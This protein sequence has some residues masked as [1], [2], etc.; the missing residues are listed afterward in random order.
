M[1]LTHKQYGLERFGLSNHQRD[2]ASGRKLRRSYPARSL[3]HGTGWFVAMVAD[4]LCVDARKVAMKHAKGCRWLRVSYVSMVS[5]VI[6]SFQCVHVSESQMSFV[7]R[8]WIAGLV[9]CLVVIHAIIIGY[10]R[11]E[12]SRVR[13]AATNEIPIG[14]YYV[15]SRDHRWLTQLRVHLLVVPERRLEAKST[16]EQNRWLIH[17]VIEEKLRQLD[18][19]LLQDAVLLKVKEEIKTALDER[20]HEE[21]IE[22]VLVN[23]RIVIPSGRFEYP[24]PYNAAEPEPLYTSVSHNEVDVH[25]DGSDLM[26]REGQH[27]AEESHGGGHG[28]GH[29]AAAESGHGAPAGHGE[30]AGH[31][32]PSGGHGE[33]SAGHGE[34]ADD[35]THVD[36]SIEPSGAEYVG[37][38]TVEAGTGSGG[39]SHGGGHGS[40]SSGGHGK[41]ASHGGGH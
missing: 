24:L 11:S 34:P 13:V 27:G 23:D 16:I 4:L 30:P 12:A 17:E 15:Q 18:P 37:V 21:I 20:M 33:A 3:G 14:V 32:A 40:S 26:A 35:S 29:G 6:V 38:Q 5:R 8:Y 9:M 25:G 36:F 10:V 39:E 7:K 1:G 19:A 28:G 41:A 2:F 31:G 22:Q